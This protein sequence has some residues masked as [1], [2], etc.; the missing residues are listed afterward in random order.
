MKEIRNYK[1]IRR[2]PQIWGFTP[3]GF[4]IFVGIAALSLFSF[5]VSFSLVHLIIVVAINVLSLIVTKLFIS[6]EH[7]MKRLLNE[8]FPTEISDLTRSKK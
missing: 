3:T 4:Y 7:M 2:K 1:N 6:N 5:A 8:K